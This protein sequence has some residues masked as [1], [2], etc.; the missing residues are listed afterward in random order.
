MVIGDDV[1]E[2]Q[3]AEVCIFDVTD[4]AGKASCP[5]SMLGQTLV[6]SLVVTFA[7]ARRVAA[8]I[9]DVLNV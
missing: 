9:L 4:P 1:T 5:S 2:L 3:A 6:L 7:P 8:R